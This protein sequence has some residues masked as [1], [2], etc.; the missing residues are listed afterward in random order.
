MSRVIPRNS[1]NNASDEKSS[2][3]AFRARAIDSQIN[4]DQVD[5]SRT[6]EVQVL[7]ENLVQIGVSGNSLIKK[8]FMKRTLRNGFN[9]SPAQ[10]QL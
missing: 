8:H 3:D 10:I 5:L 4:Y 1:P 6:A 7:P 2:R 9:Y